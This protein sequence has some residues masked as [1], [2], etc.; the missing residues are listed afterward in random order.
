MLAL[1]GCG[2]VTTS[3]GGSI[4]TPGAT[5]AIYGVEATGA[6][7]TGTFL[8]TSGLGSPDGK[9]AYITGA[10]SSTAKPIPSIAVNGTIPLGFAP[11]AA[12]IDQS[13]GVAVAPGT[14][15][16]F[17]A[18]VS[19][20]TDTA[21]GKVIPIVDPGGV[22]L[23]STDFG[24]SN[25]VLTFDSAGIGNG[26][27][28]NG[29]YKTTFTIPAGTT[30]GLHSLTASVKDTNGQQ[31]ST[32]FDAL[33]VG[34]AD[35]AAYVSVQDADGNAA[36]GAT[37]TIDGASAPGY[38][39]PGQTAPAAATSSVSDDQGVAIVFATPGAAAADGTTNTLTVTLA[40][41]TTFTQTVT[42]TA[43]QVLVVTAAPPAAAAAT[44]Q[45]KAIRH[46]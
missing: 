6:T 19:N 20:G 12:Y 7:Q 22:T 46:H 18:Y 21:T 24:L 10:V 43:G 11:G 28:G 14:A 31:T 44:R 29:Q 37:V 13:A 35:A 25:Q 16:Q 40:D 45:A 34:A 32:T 38:V 1:A 2:G 26:P 3:S 8:E 15:V 36:A 4:A 30:T 33:V 5:P 42:L 9:T 27:L 41:G 39:G 23:S 17:R